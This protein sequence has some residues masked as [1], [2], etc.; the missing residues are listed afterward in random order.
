[1]EILGF[2]S[3]S[4]IKAMSSVSVLYPIC[5]RFG[6]VGCGLRGKSSEKTIKPLLYDWSCGWLAHVLQALEEAKYHMSASRGWIN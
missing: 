1:M 6:L 3:V 2:L 4:S 5:E